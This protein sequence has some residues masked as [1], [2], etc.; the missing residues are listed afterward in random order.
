SNGVDAVRFDLEWIPSTEP[1]LL[2]A[3]SWIPRKGTREF[4]RAFA[5][6]RTAHPG[7]R[8]TILGSGIPCERVLQDFAPA[9]QDAV[10][11][12]PSASREELPALMARDQIFVLP[13]YFEGMPL[14]LLEAMAAGLPCVTT[15]ICGMRDLVLHGTNG[16]LINPGDT[17]GVVATLHAL[18]ASSELRRR[19]GSAARQSARERTWERSAGEMEA[20][21][22]DVAGSKPRRFVLQEGRWSDE[23]TE[24]P[25]DRLARVLVKL[26]EELK[27]ETDPFR[28]ME[29]WKDLHIAGRILD[30][31]CGTGWKAAS[32]ER[33]PS[34]SAIAVDYDFRL[35]QFGRK[36]FG[37]KSPV[38][39]DGCALPF[40]S[41][42][43]DWV[44]AIEVIEHLPRPDL[45]LREIH[46]VLRPG[47]RLLLTTPNRLQ[48]LRPWHPRWFYRA[49][50]RRIVLEPSH[51]REF[52]L[53]E[54]R[55][56]L[57]PGLEI[58]C[59]RYRGTLC[60]RPLPIGIDSLPQPFRMWWAQGIEIVGR[61]SEANG[62]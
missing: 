4:T 30:L 29:Q 33:E 8:C 18:L 42:R 22:G 55:Q 5:E 47:G 60:G 32:L 62:S 44:L 53:R 56:L 9:D 17:H 15:N 7:L 10:E 1:K 19:I 46:R 36:E 6:L 57:P 26:S 40:P 59:L 23:L 14:T 58:E 43:F 16:F 50:R 54:L 34:N 27:R 45:F 13:S 28:E 31:G 39:S 24:A 48:Y 41:G 12:L 37:V 51:V 52:T 35:L 2:F 21:L 11:V 25:G 38:Q 3:G 49:L 20:V 61:K